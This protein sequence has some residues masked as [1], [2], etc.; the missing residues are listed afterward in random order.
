MAAAAPVAPPNPGLPP[1][2]RAVTHGQRP[3]PAELF[4]TLNSHQ[5][6]REAGERGMGL[7]AYLEVHDPSSQYRDGFDAFQRQLQVAGISVMSD[8][9]TGYCSDSWEAFDRDV[10]TRA[11]GYE[12][13]MRVCKR[14]SGRNPN[15]RALYAST[16]QP[17]GSVIEP[18]ANAAQARYPQIAPAIMLADLVAMT[19]PIQG[20]AYR[21]FYLVNDAPSQR[22]NRVAQGAEIPRAKLLGADRTVR[23]HKYGKGLDMTYEILR[24]AR[25]DLIGLHLAR[26]QVQTE[27]DKV[28]AAIDVFVNGDGNAN[29]AATVSNL[30]TL[31]PAATVGTLTAKAWLSFKAL[32][33]NPYRLDHVLAQS[34]PVVQLEL[35]NLG[36]ANIPMVAI[37]AASGLGQLN[38]QQP[39]LGEG[40][41]VGLTSDAPASRIVGFDSRFAIEHVTE[42]GSEIQEMERFME[43]QASTIFMSYE[44]GFI[45]FD[46]LA[47]RVL[48]LSA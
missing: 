2:P 38:L 6:I 10:N 15:T 46:Q 12:W 16:D 20:D 37:N 17:V 45:V 13:A 34:G 35:L 42:I 41:T 48:N 25:I 9:D 1:D 32:F 14:A 43:R 22:F 36:S 30:T 11:L 23:L 29:T 8:A 24:R 19:T 47:C 18:F 21:A 44:D 27:I 26:M 31:D 39:Q 40:V 5:F 28:A 4:R 33:V 7:S 3:G